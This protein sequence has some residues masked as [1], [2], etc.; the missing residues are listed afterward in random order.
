MYY[1]NLYMYIPPS[2]T[3]IIFPKKLQE[4]LR[5]S[6]ESCHNSPV[7]DPVVLVAVG[8]GWCSIAFVYAGGSDSGGDGSGA[9]SN[10]LTVQP[11]LCFPSTLHKF[12]GFWSVFPDDSHGRHAFADGFTTQWLVLS[13]FFFICL[14]LFGGCYKVG[15]KTSYNK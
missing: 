15:S 8:C 14:K 1:T 7:I 4:T 3:L 5:S 6:V 12:V 11:M 2:K 10:R 9:H 13:L